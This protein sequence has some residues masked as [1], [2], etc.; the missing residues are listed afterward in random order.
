MTKSRA[1]ERFPGA[2]ALI[3]NEGEGPMKMMAVRRCVF[4]AGAA[5]VL[6][7]GGTQALA[8]PA[9]VSAGQG[10]CNERLCDRLCQSVGSIGGVCNEDGFCV[11]F[12]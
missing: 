6:G 9:P 11:C 5:A 1:G 4:G 12:L 7:F 10:V 3:R 2:E 8:A